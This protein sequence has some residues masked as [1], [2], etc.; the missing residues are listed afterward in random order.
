MAD[1]VASAGPE[2]PDGHWC[3]IAG[4]VR[5][6]VGRRGFLVPPAAP[7]PL[8]A[9]PSMASPPTLDPSVGPAPG[10]PELRDR[11]VADGAMDWTRPF[12]LFLSGLRRAVRGLDGC[13]DLRA[14]F[15]APFPGESAR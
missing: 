5:R 2:E 8:L 14:P 4:P 12:V 9:Q 6:C 11:A 7:A 10:L 1:P 13:D 15:S 3:D